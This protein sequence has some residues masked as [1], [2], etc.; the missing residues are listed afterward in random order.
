MPQLVSANVSYRNGAVAPAETCGEPGDGDAVVN[1]TVGR[2]VFTQPTVS[3]GPGGELLV[4]GKKAIWLSRDKGL[5]FDRLCQPPTPPCLVKSGLESGLCGLRPGAALLPD[6][7]TIL[8]TMAGASCANCSSHLW[9]YRGRL[10]Q[11]AGA[12][13]GAGAARPTACA[14]EPGVELPARP[15]DRLTA[16]ATRFSAAGDGN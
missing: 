2:D 16:S 12:R 14:W 11:P 3:I 5:T 9:V 1:D 7:E 13:A 8:A 4:C 15:T 6:G 10:P